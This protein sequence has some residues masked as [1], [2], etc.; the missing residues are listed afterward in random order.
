MPGV[1]QQVDVPDHLRKGQEGLGDGDVA[2]Q[3]LGELVGGPRPL[4]DQAWSFSARRRCIAKRS[5]ISATWSV[6]GSPWPGRTISAGSSR[7]LRERREVRT[8]AFGRSVEPS[9][10]RE[11]SGFEEM[12]A[13]RW[14]A[15]I[16]IVRSE[17]QKTVSEG[18]W[19]GPELDLELAVA[20]LKALAVG[21]R[22]RDLGVRAP[23]AE[24]PRDAAQGEDQVLGDPVA[25]HQPAGELVVGLGVLAEASTNG[26]ERCRSR[27]PRRRSATR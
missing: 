20:E 12:W 10:G 5:S 16:R 14:S 15:Q 27:R 18:L 11:S 17:S 9:S 24:A 26:D 7:V 13:I 23:G 22:A 6:I 3:L 25:A 4:R 19:P 1:D 8:S 2:P 21:E